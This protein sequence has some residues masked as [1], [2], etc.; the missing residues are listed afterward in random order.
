MNIVGIFKSGDEGYKE[1]CEFASMVYWRDLKFNLVNFPDYFFSLKKE[2]KIIGC[3]GLNNF[4]KC[5]LLVNDRRFMEII[6]KD[7]SRYGEQSVLAVEKCFKGILIL[8]SILLEYSC[9]INIDK[10]VFVAG[11]TPTKAAKFIGFKITDCGFADKHI[12]PALE[13]PNFE[14]WFNKNNPKIGVIDVSSA[15]YISQNFFRKLKNK[16]KINSNIEE[17]INFK[18]YDFFNLHKII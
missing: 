8:I 6:S 13:K 9:Y 12:L 7:K 15:P 5:P 10:I 11:K 1:T 4:V 17:F 18:R 2:N 16:V 14:L 3:I